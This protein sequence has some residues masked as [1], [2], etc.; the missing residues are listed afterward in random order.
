MPTSGYFPNY[1]RIENYSDDPLFN[2]AIKV[3]FD[4]KKERRYYQ[5]MGIKE[6][7]FDLEV[8]HLSGYSRFN[9]LHDISFMKGKKEVFEEKR[10][11]GF[12]IPDEAIKKLKR[13]TPVKVKVGYEWG[14]KNY[15]DIW[16]FDFSDENEVGFYIR[17]LTFW[18]G[19]KL[20]LK[21]LL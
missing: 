18:Q 16:L 8:E 5:T 17:R 12:F 21:R 11:Q 20:F 10:K 15:S 6:S 4:T 13:L 19:I 1:I 9:A 2:V 14:D 7:L 3:W